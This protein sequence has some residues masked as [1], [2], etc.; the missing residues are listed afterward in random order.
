MDHP[1]GEIILARDFSPCIPEV[2][3]ESVDLVFQH[4]GLLLETGTL[5]VIFLLVSVDFRDGG[6]GAGFFL[7]GQLAAQ[8]VE[9][10]RLLQIF[11]PDR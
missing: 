6:V 2:L 1:S 9:Q 8:L 4:L 7:L 11:C 5:P 10:G 3:L